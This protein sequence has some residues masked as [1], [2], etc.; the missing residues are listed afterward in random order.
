MNVLQPRIA[1]FV[2]TLRNQYGQYWLEEPSSW[3][4]RDCTLG[5]YCSSVLGIL[6]RN[7]TDH[8][9][10]RFLPTNSGS[11]IRVK[12]LPGRRFEEYLTETDWRRLQQKRC[13]TDVS[14]ELQLLGNANQ[15]LN[16]GEYGRAF[17]EVISALELA[18]VRPLK[19]EGCKNLTKNAIDSFLNRETPMNVRV[20]VILLASGENIKHIEGALSALETRNRV[21]H[22]RYQPTAENLADL[23]DVMKIIQRLIGLEELKIPVITSANVLSPS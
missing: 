10:C 6:W 5:T 4:S 18:I 13:L 16:Y 3:D 23:R 15:A 11:T 1:N 8:A 2:R 20:S 21:V 14:I 22:E 12:A 19:T 9:W 7:K 17:I